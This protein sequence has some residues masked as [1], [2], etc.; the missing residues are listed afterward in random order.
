MTEL[1]CHVIQEGRRVIDEP[2]R[3]QL[4]KMRRPL[5]KRFVPGRKVQAKR[6]VV[7]GQTYPFIRVQSGIDS[8]DIVTEFEFRAGKHAL[9][10]AVIDEADRWLFLLTPD[11]RLGW[12]NEIEGLVIKRE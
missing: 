1:G 6:H 9:V 11:G 7:F 10:I 8:H 5:A 3:A 12:T 4:S 2:I